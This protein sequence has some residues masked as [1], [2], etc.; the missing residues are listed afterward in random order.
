MKLYVDEL[1]SSKLGV[2]VKVT[3]SEQAANELGV[4]A[5]GAAH[6]TYLGDPQVKQKTSG[7]AKVERE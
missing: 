4:V 2:T 3:V 1:Y 7:A 5:S 6:L